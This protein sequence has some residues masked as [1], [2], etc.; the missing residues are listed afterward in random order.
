MYTV[1]CSRLVISMMMTAISVRRGSVM[2]G[3]LFSWVSCASAMSHP[4][5]G[6]LLFGTVFLPFLV[7]STCSSSYS[8]QTFS[9][10]GIFLTSLRC[11]LVV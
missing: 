6:I 11:T 1:M 8:W 5:S 4:R 9:V 2:C 3:S 10:I 7:F